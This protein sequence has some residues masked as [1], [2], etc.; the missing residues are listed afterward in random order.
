MVDITEVNINLLSTIP[1]QFLPLQ[2]EHDVG[3]INYGSK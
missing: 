1:V 3:Q 2:F